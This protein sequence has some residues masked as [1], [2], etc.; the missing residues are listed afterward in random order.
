MSTASTNHE[1]LSSKQA[2]PSWYIFRLAAKHWRRDFNS[3]EMRLLL[4]ATLVA[5]LSM[6]M[7]TTFTDRL[8]RT[9]AYRASELIAGDLTLRSQNPIAQAYIDEAL[10]RKFQHSPSL[11][12]STMAFAN[13]TLQLSQIRAVSDNYP[14]KGK[15]TLTDKAFQPGYTVQKAPDLGQVW[16]EQRVMQALSLQVG[17]S[18]EIGDALFTV[19]KILVQDA[20]RSGNFYSPFGSILMRLEDVEKTGVIG[21]GSRLSHK[22]YFRASTNIERSLSTEHSIN[23]EQSTKQN[24][25]EQ[26]QNDVEQAQAVEA[27]AQWLTPQLTE[28][29]KL[30]GAIS[31]ETSMGTAVQRAQQYLSLASLVAVLLAG[32][33]IAM[34]S[35]R[36]SERHYQTAAL[37]RSLGAQQSQITR[38]F[39]SKIAITG[40]VAVSIGAA[41]GFGAHYILFELM[42]SL[43]PSDILP[44]RW[45][46]VL[47]SMSAGII[48]LMAFSMAP[49][50]QLKRVS[51]VRVLRRELNP[52]PIRLNVFYLIAIVCMGGLAYLLTNHLT[53]TLIFV[54]GLILMA[55]LFGSVS[56]G[57]LLGLHKI[58]HRLPKKLQIGFNQ[59]YRHRYYAISQLGAFAFIFTAIT[60]ILVVRTD[61]FSRWQASIPADTPNHFAINILPEKINRFDQFLSDAGVEGS[62]SYPIVRGR[63]IEINQQPVEKAVSKEDKPGAIRRELNLTW[64]DQLGDDVS[65]VEGQWWPELNL[66][67]DQASDK[68]ST[69]KTSTNKVSVESE[70][71]TKLG[72][73]LGD[74]LTF[75]VAGRSFD[76]NVS[77]IR[78]VKW[79]NFK[80]NFYMVFPPGTMDHLHHTY[81][82]SFYL[83]PSDHSTLIE[84]S[85]S[86]KAVSLI[87]VEQ[88]I[89]QVRDIL[90]Q[91]TVAVEY[92]LILVLAAGL[93]L[94]FA[95]LQSTLS[96]RRH[97]AAIYR[98]LG[99]SGSY[100]NQLVIFEYLW[101][102]LLAGGL[103]VLA[104]E[105]LTFVLYQQVFDA[106]WLAHAWL[107]I[108][109]PTAAILVIVLSGWFGS[110][111]V[112]QA[113]PNR[114]LRE[115]G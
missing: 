40:L 94:L 35:Q 59:L 53:L 70:L 48:V 36:F 99:A 74:T 46:P 113:S 62:V 66:A 85:R 6:T 17:D 95:T 38:I 89:Q 87:P 78:K 5:A 25:D 20:D 61:L 73:Q 2:S 72:I 88:I 14:L 55:L 76:A 100:I 112:I 115:V 21:P 23:S 1:R 18:V 19:D 22:H 92:I 93:V 80:P 102:A 44:A 86:F 108:T 51:P 30:A 84:L 67:S 26:A 105:G 82:K 65:L 8:T 77:S 52:S 50:Q 10:N 97:E 75:K 4:I 57:I 104:T 42:R 33:A 56:A 32:V 41:L 47:I 90:E 103:A 110:R 64:S 37:L 43:I 106:D 34:A 71:A 101:L 79:D 98:T 83:D 69:S 11:S 91:T 49:I 31:S 111:P 54:V 28:H 60:L 3:A 7:I 9:M 63:L 29:E 27:F 12:F 114:L 68:T 96:I 39:F 15:I 45:Q 109:T 81:L 13:D 16:V 58:N 24:S 107:W